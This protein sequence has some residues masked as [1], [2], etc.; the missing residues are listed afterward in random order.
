MEQRTRNKKQ[1]GATLI[2]VAISMF[3]VF[4]LFVLYLAA[5]NSV[6]IVK[7]TSYENIAY[8]IANKQMES[9]RA[10]TYDALPSSGTIVDSQ[11]SQIPSGAGSFVVSNHASMTGMKELVVTVTWS[12][13]GSKQVI[14]RS[15]AGTGGLNP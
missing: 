10:L 6:L 2:E 4:V 1:D 15:L 9:L 3:M 14:L 11:F 12:D 8:H 5:L 7:K 13:N